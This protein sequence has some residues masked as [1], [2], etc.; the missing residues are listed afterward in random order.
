MQ[1]WLRI[2]YES[3]DWHLDSKTLRVCKYLG[4]GYKSAKAKSFARKKTLLFSCST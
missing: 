1:A 3:V 4:E 2:Y